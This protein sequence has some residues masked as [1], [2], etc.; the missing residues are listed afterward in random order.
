MKPS[1]CNQNATSADK[2]I[3]LPAGN[4]FMPLKTPVRLT[5]ALWHSLAGSDD[6]DPSNE[7]VDDLCFYLAFAVAGMIGFDRKQT[8]TTESLLIHI[9]FAPGRSVMRLT[10]HRQLGGAKVVTLSLPDELVS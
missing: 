8:S 6:F 4:H 7:I 5:H 10:C 1:P 3:T 9:S 2:L